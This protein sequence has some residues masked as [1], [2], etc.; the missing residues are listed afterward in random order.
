MFLS[1]DLSDRY[2][3]ANLLELKVLPGITQFSSELSYDR[4]ILPELLASAGSETK[5]IEKYAGFYGIE[6]Q[7]LYSQEELL[8]K[9]TDKYIHRA[10]NGIYSNRYLD[11]LSFLSLKTVPGGYAEHQL[12]EQYIKSYIGF[13]QE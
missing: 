1:L 7:N 2:K 12:F 6:R 4:F 13:R 9:T 8:R 5:L 11:F 3:A 10:Y